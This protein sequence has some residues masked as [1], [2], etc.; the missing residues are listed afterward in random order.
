MI[1]Y[2][3][4]ETQEAAAIHARRIRDAGGLA[5]VITYRSDFHEVREIV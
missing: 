3:T 4:H 5:F 1:R 2:H